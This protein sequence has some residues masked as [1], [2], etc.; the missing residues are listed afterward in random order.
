[1]NLST[2]Q[3]A[4]HLYLEARTYSC[5]G[6]EIVESRKINVDHSCLGISVYGKKIWLERKPR[7]F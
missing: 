1:M 5:L 3:P 2:S 6:L 7:K 4:T